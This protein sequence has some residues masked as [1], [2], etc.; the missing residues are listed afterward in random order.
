MVVERKGRGADRGSGRPRTCR[1]PPAPP[2]GGPCSSP[3]GRQ[4]R[5]PRGALRR[6]PGVTGAR[7]LRGSPDERGGGRGQQAEGEQQQQA[8]GL[9]G[10]G[11]PVGADSPRGRALIAGM[12][13][14]VGTGQLTGLFAP[15]L[16]TWAAGGGAGAGPGRGRGGATP[17]PEQTLRLGPAHGGRGCARRPSHSGPALTPRELPRPGRG[18]RGRGLGPPPW[19]P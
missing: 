12:T 8:G 15:R 6:C 11:D 17:G 14:Q 18:R 16:I 9:H 19:T 10:G 13:A 7:E 1:G 2:E 3:R 4:S 5:M